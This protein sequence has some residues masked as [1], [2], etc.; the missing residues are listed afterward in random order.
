MSEI[1]VGITYVVVG[2]Q[3]LPSSVKQKGNCSVNEVLMGCGNNT[4]A[5]VLG[6]LFFGVVFQK[7]QKNQTAH[8]VSLL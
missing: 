6:G 4:G 1:P 7:A 3:S 2:C 8:G 5:G